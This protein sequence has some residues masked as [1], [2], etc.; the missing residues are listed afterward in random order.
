MTDVPAAAEFHLFLPQMRMPLDVM[1]ERARAAEAAG[2]AGLALMDHLAPPMAEGHDMWDAMVTAGWLLAATDRLVLSHLVLCDAFRH[3]AVLARQAVTLDHASGG[4]FELGIG[5][6]SVPVE[7]ERFGVF[8]TDAKARVA[9]LAETLEVVRALWSGEQV[10]FEGEYHRLAGAVQRPRPLARI[11]VVIG[12]AGPKTLRLVAAHADWWN[13]PV[14]G[15]DRLEELR[16]SVGD[17][18]VSIQ[19]MISLVPSEAE[20]EEVTSVTMRRFGHMGKGLFVGTADEVVAHFE[21]LRRRGVERFYC[22]MADFAA[23]EGLA[24]FGEHV[25]PAF[26]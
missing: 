23:P 5:W 22:W 15:L 2:F 21:D 19:Q 8:T 16:P 10:D 25:I 3:P 13:L 12:G 14:Y 9:R 20:R 17:A 7:F 24:R 1:V 4:R 6:G 11:P 18:R 26:A